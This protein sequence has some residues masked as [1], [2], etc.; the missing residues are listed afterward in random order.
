M[1]SDFLS[2]DHKC[3]E[4]IIDLSRDALREN[5]QILNLTP[6]LSSMTTK[7]KAGWNASS[8]AE[9]PRAL[10]ALRSLIRIQ[11]E[12]ILLL[13]CFFIFSPLFFHFVLLK[14]R[15]NHS[16][17]QGKWWYYPACSVVLTA[18]EYISSYRQEGQRKSSPIV[19]R[20]NFDWNDYN[21]L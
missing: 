20:V 1:L 21:P 8:I 16:I 14:W 6:T 4:W 11:H 13:S 18:D 9:W 3:I 17:S 12:A 19:T 15:R 5:N 7:R 10:T 2:L